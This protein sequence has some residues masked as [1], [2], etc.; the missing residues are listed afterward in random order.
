MTIRSSNAIG[1]LLVTG[2]LMTTVFAHA[3]TIIINSDGDDPNANVFSST[4][5]TGNTVSIPGAGNVAEC[6]LRAAIQAANNLSSATI[7]YA[8]V[9]NC[10][11][12]NTIRLGSSLPGIGSSLTVD[13]STHPC[14][15][16]AASWY[17]TITPDIVG[18]ADINFGLTI[19]ADNVTIERM[20]F[21]F[22]NMAG[23]LIDGDNVTIDNVQSLAN[24]AGLWMVGVDGGQVVNSTFSNNDDD[25]VLISN[26]QGVRLRNNQ[27][28]SAGRNGVRIINGSS[29]NFIGGVTG[30]F[31]ANTCQGNS[32]SSNSEAGIFV[33]ADSDGQIMICNSIF[34][35][36]GDGITL[37]SSDNRVGS[38]S[39]IGEIDL[40][41]L[42][43]SIWR[44][45]GHGIRMELESNGNTISRNIIGGEPGE[46]ADGNG[47]NGISIL[48]GEASSQTINENVIGYNSLDGIRMLGNARA[49][50]RGNTIRGND[51]NGI[52]SSKNLTRIG[53]TEEGEG[54]TIVLNTQNG[55]LIRQT[56]G[57]GFPSIGGNF[58][59]TDAD[60]NDLGNGHSGIRMRDLSATAYIGQ[61]SLQN[62][63]SAPNI[64]GFNGLSGVMVSGADDVRVHGNY[65][66][67]NPDGMNLG[68]QRHGVHM[69]SGGSGRVG[70]TVGSGG[71]ISPP[72]EGSGNII[73][74]NLDAGVRLAGGGTRDISI[75]GN[76][77]FANS[78]RGI[79]LGNDGNVID[80]GGSQHGPNRLQNFPELIN[81]QTFLDSNSGEIAFSYRVRTDT[82]HAAYPLL[83]DFYLVEG[84]SAQ[85]KVWLGSD[86]YPASSANEFRSG[87]FQ[88]S[89]WSGSLE[90]GFITATAT[91]SD[92]NTSEFNPSPVSLGQSGDVLFQDR[93]EP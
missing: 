72:I 86:S 79:E 66:G 5:D 19:G 33:D 87:S 16:G 85:G 61:M 52:R 70:H 18:G 13:A 10:S 12:L 21:G 91:D 47:L 17:P 48:G 50:I 36:D 67:T 4:C 93:F 75:R 84:T 59:G 57:V 69:L 62:T 39:D 64:I 42:G 92:G 41:V 76:S 40:V 26:S 8:S 53:G 45:D 44:N 89:A 6:T 3:N 54:N 78:S 25:N 88:P 7:E 11:D 27:I 55:I 74:Y 30:T 22:F 63:P 60:G 49:V 56:S 23:I 51:I 38:S 15:G 77:I 2:L 24:G 35:N 37:E 90:G 46:T 82:L 65:I 9:L 73:A 14:A 43:N 81:A 58:I 34:S 80:P 20:E 1:W 28:S 68:N 71:N 83:I 32:I 31:P 29:G